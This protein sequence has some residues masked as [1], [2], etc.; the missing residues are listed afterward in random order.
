MGQEMLLVELNP[1]MHTLRLHFRVATSATLMVELVN[2]VQDLISTS[3]G[4]VL[5]SHTCSCTPF[6][7]D[8]SLQI[9][10]TVITQRIM[11]SFIGLIKE[12]GKN[13]YNKLVIVFMC[14]KS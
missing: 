11:F 13:N 7:F 14:N 8:S 3:V 2:L 12:R 10:G 5:T 4:K 1:P 9:A 6:F